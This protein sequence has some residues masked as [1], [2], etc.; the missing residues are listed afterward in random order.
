MFGHWAEVR[1]RPRG[2]LGGFCR[3]ASAV[4]G[5]RMPEAAPGERVGLKLRGGKRRA[6]PF[7]PGEAPRLRASTAPAGSGRGGRVEERWPVV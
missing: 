1:A 4:P 7:G 3:A 6:E 5:L 2:D